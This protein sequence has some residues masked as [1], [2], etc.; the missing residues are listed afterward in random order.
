MADFLNLQGKLK[1]LYLTIDEVLF[2]QFRCWE[3]LDIYCP[4]EDT[5][6]FLNLQGKLKPLTFTNDEV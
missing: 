3:I 5:A 6:D 2:S 4:S 1:P